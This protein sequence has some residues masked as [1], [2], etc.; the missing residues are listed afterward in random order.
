MECSR[1]IHEPN[2]AL[3]FLHQKKKPTQRA[4]IKE[5]QTSI[6]TV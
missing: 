4:L 2:P 6:F 1:I 5:K 3:I